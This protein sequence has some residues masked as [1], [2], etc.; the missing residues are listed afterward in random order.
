M[1]D[2][3]SVLELMYLGQTYIETRPKDFY[4][5]AGRIQIA[6]F[7]FIQFLHYSL[8][9]SVCKHPDIIFGTL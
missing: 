9:Y 2:M 1:K 3:K 6:E 7:K 4:L 5:D 8:V